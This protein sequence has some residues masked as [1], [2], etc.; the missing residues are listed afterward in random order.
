MNKEL[1]ELREQAEKADP[2]LETALS[3]LRD[4]AMNVSTLAVFVG[5]LQ[6]EAA[7]CEFEE[8]TPAQKAHLDGRL[9]QRTRFT[10]DRCARIGK[11]LRDLADAVRNLRKDCADLVAIVPAPE[12]SDG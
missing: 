7:D 3:A 4:A 1:E 6:R 12:A 9:L 8:L 2:V 5:D 10:L 11:D